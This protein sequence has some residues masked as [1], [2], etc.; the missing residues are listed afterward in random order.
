A[1]PLLAFTASAD[2]P[3]GHVP[4]SAD[5][6]TVLA[7][8]PADPFAEDR[9]LDVEVGRQVGQFLAV[10]TDQVAPQALLLGAV[11][12]PQEPGDGLVGG[13]VLIAAAVAAGPAVRF[14][15]AGR[16]M[17]LLGEGGECE[18]DRRAGDPWEGGAQGW[19]A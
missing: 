16:P 18:G 1:S 15:A 14:A 10:E 17:K 4:G 5:G 3:L 19:V 9:A 8:D 13:R 11:D 7:F 2:V 6:G 12:A